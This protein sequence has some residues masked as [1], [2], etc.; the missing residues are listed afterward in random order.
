MRSI[1][2]LSEKGG[3]A[4]TTSVLNIA[5][6]L[7]LA[8]KRVLVVDTDPQGNA[9]HVLLRG[10][11]ARR[12]TLAEVLTD[13]A[14]APEAIVPSAFDG[15]SVLP[16]DHTLADAAL[17]LA[18]E[19]GRE[20]RLRLALDEVAGDFD[21]IL[22][23]TAP[24]RSVLTTN[25]L[26]FARE[27]YVPIA[28]GLF[29]VLGLGQLQ[30]DVAQV[31][32]YLDNKDVRIA[33]IVLVMT[34]KNNV[35]KDLEEQLRAMFGPIVCRARVPRSIKLEEAHS[36]HESV[37]TYAPKSPGATAYRELTEEILGHEQREADRPSDPR[38]NP[39]AD[40]AA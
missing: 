24:T 23:D 29:G 8:R 17:L 16:T 19:V 27:L 34:E 35:A 7:G 11:A 40:H 22:V 18:N 30:T 37:F 36:R 10:E 31:R 1:A 6:G 2:F 28:P 3:V 21:F 9:S 20:R 39:P 25:V 13:G 33:G 4:K 12:P 15:V 32:R 26:N 5:A 14:G 38:R